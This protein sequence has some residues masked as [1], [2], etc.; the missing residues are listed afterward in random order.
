MKDIAA[1]DALRVATELELI[2][3]DEAKIASEILDQGFKLSDSSESWI[4]QV[5]AKIIEL[6]HILRRTP[7]Y[8]YLN[9]GPRPSTPSDRSGFRA[10]DQYNRLESFIA[11][12]VHLRNTIKGR[13]ESGI[14]DPA[15]LTK[16]L[17]VAPD[18]VK[19]LLEM[20]QTKADSNRLVKASSS[21]DDIHLCLTWAGL[22]ATAMQHSDPQHLIKA[23]ED[24]EAKRLLSARIAEHAAAEFYAALGHEVIDVSIG[25]IGNS[26]D[27]WKDYDLLV[28]GRP[29]DVKNSRRSFSSRES[30]VE[31][32]V[33]AFK[34]S[35]ASGA[36]VAVTG[37]LSEY[38]TFENLVESTSSCRI[39]GEVTESEIDR[40]NVWTRRRFDHILNIDGIWKP[41]Y[42]PGWIFEYPPEHYP[43]R[44][45]AIDCIPSLIEKL[46]ACGVENYR[47]P[48][49]LLPLCPDR[50]L[51][52]PLAGSDQKGKI[53][54]DLHSLDDEIGFSR[55]GL[56]IYVMGL[57]LEAIA[58]GEQAGQ[59]EGPLKALL[60]LHGSPLSRPL[61]LE[62]SQSYVANL[63]DMLVQV[64]KEVCRQNLK[65]IG[66][67][68]THPLILLGQRDAGSWMTLI[69]YCGGWR[70]VPVP[71]RC[72]ASPLFFGQHE[73][74]PSC[75]R[76]VCDDCGFCSRGCDWVARRQHDVAARQRNPNED[77][78]FGTPTRTG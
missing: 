57:F 68:L 41:K 49:W 29:I 56:F 34:L 58:N 67:R 60:F 19:M 45:T 70:Q 40:L 2:S 77:G 35:R 71:A 28:N 38:C 43:G 50:E 42:Q 39:L 48:S 22:G 9:G 13:F 6:E 8:R 36:E 64:E 46:K 31:Y 44:K 21:A 17:K 25:Q 10:L 24:Y 78:Y 5:E 47:I 27:Q 15:K 4:S 74:C 52:S 16:I 30:Y 54:S 23:V 11:E 18:L 37:V 3:D 62:D 12:Y 33:P 26:D 32:C 76:L 53:L 55:P 61:G 69:A 20:Q 1:Q 65:L 73:V 7:Y 66:F 59:L 63:I 75:G 72:G 51:A 14:G